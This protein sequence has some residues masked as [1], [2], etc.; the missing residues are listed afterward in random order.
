MGPVIGLPV[1]G[2]APMTPVA[3]D[4]DEKV[5]RMR[6]TELETEVEML[7]QDMDLLRRDYTATVFGCFIMS[8]I[9][10]TLTILHLAVV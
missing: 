7:E 5:M 1:E 2:G 9:A 6:V 10:F 4:L 3:H 8:F